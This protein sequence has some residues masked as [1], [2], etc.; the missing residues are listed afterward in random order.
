MLQHLYFLLRLTVKSREQLNNWGEL[1]IG[2][3][4]EFRGMSI[5]ETPMLKFRNGLKISMMKGGYGGFYLLF[6]EIFVEN[7]YEPTPDFVVQDGWKTMDIGANMGF[8]SC[9][10]GTAAKNVQLISVE[11]V[12]GYYEKLKENLANNNITRAFPLHAAAVGIPTESIVISSWFT[13]S[14]EQK[15]TW[16]PPPEGSRTLT[17]SVPGMTLAE[18]LDAGNMEHCDLMKMDIEGAEFPI[19]EA[20]PPEVWSRI[21]RIVMETHEKS[22]TNDQQILVDTLT[23]QGFRVKTRPMFLY[24]IRPALA[25]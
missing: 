24:A 15:V 17:E 14:G 3:I 2:T 11:P 12:G 21:D 7:C 10:A 5:P 20:T 18:I 13:A 1:I 25:S 23:K 4:R 6:P 9:K 22:G 19:F 16:T 8:Y